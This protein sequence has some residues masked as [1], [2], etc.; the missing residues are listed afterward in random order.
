MIQFQGPTYLSA[1]YERD[2]ALE[3]RAIGQSGLLPKI[4]ITAF[5]NHINGT[6][7]QPDF[8]SNSHTNDL[9]YN[10]R[11]AT[12][13]LRQPLFNKQKMAEYRQGEYQAEYGVAVFEATLRYLPAKLRLAADV[14]A[15]GD[16]DIASANAYLGSKLSF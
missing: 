6:Q 7:K 14:G 10:S 3:N 11:G 1:G 15:L 4:G 13:Q 9:N 8:F 2:A 16:D 12:P 5:D